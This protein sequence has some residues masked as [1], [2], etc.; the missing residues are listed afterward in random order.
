MFLSPSSCDR[1]AVLQLVDAAA[2]HHLTVDDDVAA[3]R[4]GTIPT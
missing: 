3:Q 2:G 1:L 4:L